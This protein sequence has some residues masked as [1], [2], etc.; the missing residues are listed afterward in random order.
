MQRGFTLTE[1]VVVIVIAGILASVAIPR[2]L[3]TSDIDQSGAADD[4]RAALQFAR[5]AA[6]YG[7]RYVCV[8]VSGNVLT[9]TR[10][11]AAPESVASPNCTQSLALP[12]TKAGC[13]ANAVCPPSGVTL[14]MSP[15]SLVFY[16]GSGGASVAATISVAGV[17]I[18]LDAAT[19]F[20]Q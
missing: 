13:A 6:V 18:T 9:V 3:D 5:K 16:P 10:D 8:G 1:L 14:S 11:P 7:R 4:V 20:V 2:M 12:A 17:P 19:G 15:T